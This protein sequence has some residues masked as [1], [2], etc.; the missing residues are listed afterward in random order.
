MTNGETADPDKLWLQG[1]KQVRRRHAA[2]K[3]VSQYL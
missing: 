3:P 1:D 2:V